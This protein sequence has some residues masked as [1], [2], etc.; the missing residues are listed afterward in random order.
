MLSDVN[1][2]VQLH[3]ILEERGVRAEI[4]VKVFYV[5]VDFH[6]MPTPI[7]DHRSTM[8][9]LSFEFFHVVFRIDQLLVDGFHVHHN[10]GK[11][12]S[13]VVALV[14][15]E[16]LLLEVKYVDVFFDRS[17]IKQLEASWAFDATK[18]NVKLNFTSSQLDQS[19]LTFC[20]LFSCKFV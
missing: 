12:R 9:A 7:L 3:V 20:L 13:F 6:N 10:T 11:T 19:E 15:L 16:V 14:A 18:R 1:F 5:H 8:V 2:D 4:T 17:P